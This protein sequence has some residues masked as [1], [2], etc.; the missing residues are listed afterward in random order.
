LLNLA[1]DLAKLHYCAEFG[2]TEIAGLL[3]SKGAD[4]M[5]TNYYR[6]GNEVGR[7]TARDVA[8]YYKKTAV[9]ALIDE[10]L[11]AKASTDN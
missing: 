4:P 2:H 1:L 6:M 11:K 8:V 3:L 5:L 7:D 9:V 10:H